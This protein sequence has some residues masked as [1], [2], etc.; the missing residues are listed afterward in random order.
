MP[1]PRGAQ[2]VGGETTV[3]RT[4]LYEIKLGI[5]GSGFG[6]RDSGLGTRGSGLGTRGSGLGARGAGCEN[7]EHLG[8]LRGE[9]LAEQRP[10]VD[11]RKKIARASRSSG[12]AGVVADLG[13]VERELHERGH[14]QRAVLLDRGANLS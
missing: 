7:R 2:D 3:G 8:E 10:D 13:V 5:R 11:A 12:R 9:Q 1:G 14:R 4:G 6:I